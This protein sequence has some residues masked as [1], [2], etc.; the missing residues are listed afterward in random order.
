MKRKWIWLI[1]FICLSVL[2][3]FREISFRSINALIRG[4]DFFYAKTI[5]IESIKGF[6]I[7]KLMKLKVLLTILYSIL[8]ILISTIGIKLSFSYRFTYKVILLIYSGIIIIAI[9]L[10]LSSLTFSNF[11]T[12]YFYLRKLIGIIHNPL[13]FMFVSISGISLNY[14]N[15]N[16]K[17]E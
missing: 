3:Y 11:E 4:E 10:I 5:E 2:S 14:L 9:L 17:I 8:F 7:D 6:S 1:F 15:F 16:Q 13:I 12:I